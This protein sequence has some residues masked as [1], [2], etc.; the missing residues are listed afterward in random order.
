MGSV[1]PLDYADSSMRGMIG[2]VIKAQ[3]APYTAEAESAEFK[4]WIVQP[5]QVT[6]ALRLQAKCAAAEPPAPTPEATLADTM[7][8]YLEAQA[9]SHKRS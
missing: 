7:K 9:A 8:E 5:A 4:S 6:F 2:D 3:E 1:S